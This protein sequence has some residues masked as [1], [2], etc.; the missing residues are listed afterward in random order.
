M[1]QNAQSLS[2]ITHQAVVPCIECEHVV[3]MVFPSFT[4]ETHLQ[5][6]LLLSTQPAVLVGYR[7]AHCKHNVIP[8]Y[9][10]ARR[11]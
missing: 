4:Y 5:R 9:N 3:F 2:R 7:T 8:M 10:N 6:Y 1:L 11:G